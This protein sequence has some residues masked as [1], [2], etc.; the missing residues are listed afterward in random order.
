MTL[1]ANI[2]LIAAAVLDSGMPLPQACE[3]V[4]AR[5]ID[6]ALLRTKGNVTQSA[7]LLGVHR[8]TVDNKLRARQPEMRELKRQ[9]KAALREAGK[10]QE[11]ITKRGKRPLRR[12]R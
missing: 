11:Q 10:I 6:A 3:L 7:A 2:D 5:I 4:E 9:H 8:N 12:G 1:S